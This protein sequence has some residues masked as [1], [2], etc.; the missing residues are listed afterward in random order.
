MNPSLMILLV[1]HFVFDKPVP[2]WLWVLCFVTNW[3]VHT[4]NENK[5]LKVKVS[6]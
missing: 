4:V 3:I 5:T 2:W 6:Q 1:T